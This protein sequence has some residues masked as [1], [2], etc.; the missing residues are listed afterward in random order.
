VGRFYPVSIETERNQLAF[1]SSKKRENSNEANTKTAKNFQSNP[2]KRTGY[3]ENAGYIKEQ[4]AIP[5]AVSQRMI[6]R[7]AAFCGIP[8]LLSISTLI[9]SYLILTYTKVVLSPVIVLLL[10]LGFFGLGFV[11]ITYGAIS[12]SWEENRTGGII[13][14]Q[15]FSTNWGR[16]TDIWRENKQKKHNQ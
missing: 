7:V 11:G 5:R 16:V 10:S 12:A 1:A 2:A 15:E 3:S 8:T 14:L 13:G 9:I 4:L 6:R